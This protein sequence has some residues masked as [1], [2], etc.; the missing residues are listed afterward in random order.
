MQICLNFE[1]KSHTRIYSFNSLGRIGGCREYRKLNS[2][3]WASNP[4]G[5]AHHVICRF[6]HCFAIINPCIKSL[7][8]GSTLR[9]SITKRKVT[10]LLL[11]C[12]DHRMPHSCL[13]CTIFQRVG[14]THILV[15]PNRWP[16]QQIQSQKHDHANP[17]P[18]EEHM[19]APWVKAWA[20]KLHVRLHCRFL[21]SK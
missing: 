8:C 3:D 18:L 2:F 16:P 6:T 12:V 4:H 10:I 9:F 21:K 5:Q 20:T 7:I 17:R 19:W 11:V 13:G 15:P 14:F 1:L